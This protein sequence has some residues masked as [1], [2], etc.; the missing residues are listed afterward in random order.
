[1][2]GWSKRK[3]DAV[4][5]AFLQFLSKCY[6]DSKDAGRICLGE[7]LYWGQLYVITEIFDALEED[8]HKILIL[9]SR[10]LGI[11]TLVRALTVFML[12]IHQGLKGALV[13][14]SAPN[15]D[16]ARTELVS[17][18]RNLPAALKFPKVKGTGEGNREGLTLENDSRILFK[19]AGVK[20]SKSSGTLGRSV[21]LSFATLSE[22]C[23]FENPEGLEAFEQSLSDINPDRLYVYES[24]ARGYNDWHSLFTEAKK[25]TAHCKTL[26]IGWWAKPSQ[27][28][29]PD[30]ADFLRYGEQPPTA[31]E[32]EKIK[33]VRERHGV[34]IDQSQLA[35]IRRRMDPGAQ[36]DGDEEVEYE[37]NST[38]IQEQPWLEEDAW[39][40]TGSQF[41]PSEKLTDQ[42][43]RF[44][45]PEYQRFMFT[46]GA[47]F[48]HMM[49]HKAPNMKSTD[50]K[51]WEE[52]VADGVYC[53]GVDPA[54]GENARNDRASIEIGRCYSDGIDQVAEFASPHVTPQ[55]LAWVLASL[56]GWY[57]SA[58]KT[59]VRYIL[60]LNGPGSAVFNEVKQLRF[61][62]ENKYWPVETEEK[63]LKNIFRNVKTFIYTRPDGMS[64]GQNYH[65]KT[66]SGLKVMVMNQ[67]R[68]YVTTQLFRVRSAELV[69]EMRGIAQDGDTI[70][71]EG[72]K[73]DDRVVSAA[74]MT[75]YWQ[76]SIRR[77]LIQQNRTREAELAKSRLTI[78]DQV[79]L[80]QQNQLQ[81]FFD[82]KR[83]ERVTQHRQQVHMAW[84]YGRR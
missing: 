5:T 46:C 14:D 44:V 40:N 56:M 37:G 11:S 76:T 20:K 72:R 33:L 6:V 15:R 43:M 22:L 71:A 83:K 61:Q 2:A 4:E 3:R 67:L 13:F 28:I 1:M 36:C 45:S 19:S 62:L 18:I 68:D 69:E 57:G 63:G 60:E 58:E 29:D 55:Q 73:K 64:V 52:P 50:L 84:R 59:D 53:M 49:I 31:K 17:M 8:I 42:S 16:E 35:W 32:L 80:F 30:E 12:G 81:A 38:R 41:F 70:G 21:G 54:F 25:D 65:F 66:T 9:K 47:E 23:S 74:F 39:Q 77:S 10:Q 78:T 26:F 75:H 24:T 34:Q 7:N 79:S 27:R 51:V 82:S 48:S